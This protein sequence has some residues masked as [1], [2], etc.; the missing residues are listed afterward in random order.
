MT[1]EGLHYLAGEDP[2]APVEGQ[3]PV[4]LTLIDAETS[5][6]YGG[7]VT[8]SASATNL[9]GSPIPGVPVTFRLGNQGRM[10]LTGSDGIATASFFVLAQPGVIRLERD[11]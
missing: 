4:I 8:Y 2:A 3:N 7:M 6:E 9:D 10:V 11:L 5:G 1:N